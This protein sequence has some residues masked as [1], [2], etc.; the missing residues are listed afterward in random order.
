MIEGRVDFSAQ[1]TVTFGRPA[2]EAAAGLA[3]DWGAE[4]VMILASG[5]LNRETDVVSTVAAALGPK[6]AGTFDRM[7]AHTPRSAVIEATA[8]AREAGA[9]LLVTVGGGSVTDG[10]KAV[11]LAL[12]N[13]ARTVE[14]MDRIRAGNPVEAPTVRQLSIP[15]T[16]SAG[17]FSALCGVTDTRTS[18]KEGFRHPLLVPRATVL[19]P[20]VT[21]HTPEWL[22]L[23]TGIRAV[24]H[25]AEGICSLESHP[26]G[27]AQA[28]EGLR[29]LAAGLP[30]VKA[31]PADLEARL[32]CQLG[33]WLSMGPLSTGVPMGASH[34][35]GYVLG[36][37]HGVPHGHTSCLMLPAT[38]RWNR[39]A[40]A[41]RQARAAAAMGRTDGDLAAALEALIAGLGMPT[42][43]SEVGIGPDAFDAIAAG[44]MKTPWAPRNPRPI[45]GPA[46]VREILDLAA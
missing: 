23:S 24:D 26:Y 44:A 46:Q 43:L 30:R 25:C 6:H 11:C 41:D 32:D 42:R 27:D 7:P 20:A 1:E 35:I 19:D 33:C 8:M 18:T 15:T 21:V 9:D 5:T 22:F 39:P 34:G 10:A 12:A 38:M 17:E 40:N 16:L 3:A 28:L 45:E 29:R 36:A 31:D 13:G 4:R 37:L 2:A 14:D